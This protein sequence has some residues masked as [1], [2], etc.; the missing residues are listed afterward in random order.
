MIREQSLLNGGEE[1][2]HIADS[3]QLLQPLNVLPV[4]SSVENNLLP[5]QSAGNAS[6]DEYVLT[7]LQPRGF[8]PPPCVPST[9]QSVFSS[10]S[11]QVELNHFQGQND[12][13]Q[14]QEGRGDLYYDGGGNDNS[15]DPE[16]RGKIQQCLILNRDYQVMLVW[17]N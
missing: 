13:Y 8:E 6:S 17:T 3:S 11:W 15:G 2:F 9:S 7:E 4:Q 12:D 5:S 14:Q 10:D 1:A 16:L